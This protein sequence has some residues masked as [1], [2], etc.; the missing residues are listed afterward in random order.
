M[1]NHNT[2]PLPGQAAANG[3]PNPKPEKS[4]DDILED[5]MFV[6]LDNALVSALS[7]AT[8][9][10]LNAMVWPSGRLTQAN[11][12]DLKN[13]KVIV[14]T[15]SDPK[16]LKRAMTVRGQCKQAGAVIVNEWVLHGLG[17]EFSTLAEW[18]ESFE[19]V[20]VL[21][22]A[23]PWIVTRPDPPDE[24]EESPPPASLNGNGQHRQASDDR[25]VIF[26]T[27]E[28]HKVNDQAVTALLADP[29]IF[30]RNL[31]LVSIAR[32]S[33][34]RN[35]DPAEIQRAEGTPI[36]R[37][38]QAAKLREDL[39]RVARWQKFS[40]PDR[41]GKSKVV[42]AHPPTWAV[43][44]IL[45]REQWPDIRYL[46]GILEAPTLRADGSVIE[47]AGYD[48]RSGLLYVP[49]GSFPPVPCKPTQEDARQAAD[50]LLELVKDFPFKKDHKAAWL[51]ALLTPLARF[52]I[53][54]ACPM[55]L[56]EANTSGAG[57]TLLCD[58]IAVIATGRVM[59]RTGYYHDP[60][61]MDKQI[62]ATALAGDCV[63]LFDNVE[64]GGRLGN[65]S[66]DR[67]LTGRTY[68]GRVLGKSEMTPD[69]D[70]NCV[71][72]CTGNN[73]TLCGDVVRRIIP[74]RLESPLEHPEE[75]V[76]F[77]I[78]ACACGCKGDLLAHV[79]GHRERLVVAALTILRSYILAGKPDQELTPMDFTAWSGMIRNAVRWTTGV[80]PAA[81]RKDLDQSDSEHSHCAAF[82][83][84]WFE[85]QEFLNVKGMTSATLVKTLKAAGDETRFEGIR[86]AM[87]NL[88]PR[89]KTGEL[90]SS[91]SIGMKIQAIRDKAF[92]TKRFEAISED[93]R[94]K[95]WAVIEA[96]HRPPAGESREPGESHTHGRE[97]KDDDKCHTE[98][99]GSDWDKTLQAQQ[100]HPEED[101]FNNDDWTTYP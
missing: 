1:L 53:D 83:E 26:V 18:R 47:T 67:A 43:N 48:P 84:G 19:L 54:G 15:G 61:E 41:N 38:I 91:G 77:A 9:I 12:P 70:L 66:L 56:F 82:V 37:P 73:L 42:D 88:W 78:K 29:G 76:D 24:E 62:V 6:C 69:L 93:K 90:P 59:T 2:H 14:A 97:K 52:L 99:N 44:A 72:F 68:R 98:K 49:N 5:Q 85:V 79:R 20:N 21:A 45:A 39:T 94:A 36:I 13:W 25:A 23:R 46:V 87:A 75:R 30:Q 63:V 35:G 95:V 50:V 31:R 100:T 55:F 80:D 89:I 33:K 51:A 10:G 64:N 11:L 3:K 86:D 71:F 57:K 74:C 101:R 65:S 8:P 40:Q 96:Q 22:L 60:V 17:A 7:R 16:S 4:L 32:D 34:P 58:V 27:T 81:G 92:G 28:E